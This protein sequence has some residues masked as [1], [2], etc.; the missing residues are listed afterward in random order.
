MCLAVAL[1]SACAQD[2][3]EDMS[4]TPPTIDDKAPVEIDDRDR[5]MMME[6]EMT[7]D[8]EGKLKDVA[9]GQATGVA[10]AAFKEG[11]YY[12][13][14]T[15]EGLPQPADGE[16]F[17]GWIVRSIP[18][19]YI[20]VGRVDRINGAYT[21]VYTSKQ[22]LTGYAKYVLT[23]EPEDNDPSPAKHILEGKMKK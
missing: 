7:Y 1:V 6:D 19:S 5:F 11:T 13:L 20:S 16:F 14:A 18:F 2:S 22:D 21:N 17:E 23:L 15:F 12:L 9:D 3:S 4:A 8:F 10:K